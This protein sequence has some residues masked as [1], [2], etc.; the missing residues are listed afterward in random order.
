PPRRR[1]VP[2][3]TLFRSGLR[4]RRDRA[5]GAGRGGRLGPVRLPVPRVRRPGAAAAPSR[6]PPP[7]AP[8]AAAA[9]RR[10]AAGRRPR[11]P[12]LPHQDRK[13]TRLNS[14]HVKI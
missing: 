4:P 9:A 5:G 13:S 10:P 6:P 1:L 7:P 11:V 14:S 8:V 12:R 3:T 2:Y